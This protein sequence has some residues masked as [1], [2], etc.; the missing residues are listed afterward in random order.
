MPCISRPG[1]HHAACGAL[2]CMNRAYLASYHVSAMLQDVARSTCTTHDPVSIK[3]R[4]FDEDSR[5]T[6]V[7]G[8]EH[9]PTAKNWMVRPPTPAPAPTSSG[10][11][12]A[13]SS[14]PSS[15]CTALG[16]C[17]ISPR[18]PSRMALWIRASQ[19]LAMCFTTRALAS[20]EHSLGP[21]RITSSC[22][23]Q[24]GGGDRYGRSLRRGAAAGS[25][26]RGVSTPASHAF[27]LSYG[28]LRS[29]HTLITA[30]LTSL[31]PSLLLPPPA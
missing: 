5:Q 25:A 23:C 14:E 19:G 12:G 26:H 21:S 9:P 18:L 31:G 11:I 13:G 10:S 22:T 16:A 4:Q 6:D 2:S 17:T 28:Q 15:F 1:C 7:W 3:W 24:E 29:T 20:S 27:P 8:R 30:L